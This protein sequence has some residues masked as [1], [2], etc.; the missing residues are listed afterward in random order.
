MTRLRLDLA[1]DGTDF[2]GWAVQPGQRTVAGQLTEAVEILVGVPVP[3]TAAGRTDAGVHA[4]GQV[5]H[6][7][8]PTVPAEHGPAHGPSPDP[9]HRE[10]ARRAT[11]RATIGRRDPVAALTV[12]ALNALLPADI[13]VRSVRAAPAGFDARFSAVGRVYA[14]RITDSVCDP[15]RRRDTLTWPRALD[16]E[17]M[18]VASR[19]LVGLHNFVAYCRAREGR[20]S[21]RDLLQLDWSRAPDGVLTATVEADA[22]CHSM[23]RSL[24]GAL[25]AV[26]DGRWPVDRPASLL[27]TDRRADAVVVAPAHGLS[28]LAVRYPP[29]DRLAARAAQ[30]RASRVPQNSPGGSRSDSAWRVYTPSPGSPR[31]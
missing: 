21:I 23:V 22:F 26:G 11:G 24:I 18:R 2:A 5:V 12:R 16:L 6:L 19:P 1:Y 17:A 10:T 27:G 14:Y 20:T 28:L 29:E 15:L 8:V 7:D 9:T 25:L 31:N 30:T 13:R 4:G 3:M